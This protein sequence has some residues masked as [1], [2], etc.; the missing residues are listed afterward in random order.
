M[1][2]PSADPELKGTA[3]ALVDRMVRHPE[4]FGVARRGHRVLLH[5]RR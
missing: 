2:F 1:V 5:T 4:H 3:R